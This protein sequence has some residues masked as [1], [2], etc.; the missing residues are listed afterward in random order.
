MI[1]NRYRFIIPIRVFDTREALLDATIS[2]ASVIARKSS[3]AVQASKINLNYARDHT[4][5]DNFTFV[6]TWNSAMLLTEDIVKNFM[7]TSV[8]NEKSKL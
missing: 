2:L 3:I 6:R 5:D 4:V 8:S 1:K 7:A